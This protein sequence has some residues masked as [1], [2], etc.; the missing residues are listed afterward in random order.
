MGLYETE[1]IDHP[2]ICTIAV[3]PKEY[4]EK[5]KNRSINEKHKGVGCD[6]PGMNFERCAKR[7]KVL[8]EVESVRVNKKMIQKRLQVKNTEMKMVSVSN[9]QFANL[10][11]K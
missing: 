1:N 5:F 10:N 8:R 6:T 2:N 9:V 7:I 11:D 4:F 3:N